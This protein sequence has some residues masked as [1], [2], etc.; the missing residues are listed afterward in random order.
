MQSLPAWHHRINMLIRLDIEIDQDR[1]LVRD[2]F[3]HRLLHIALVIAAAHPTDAIRLGELGEIGIFH[4][5][6][7]VAFVEQVLPLL[8]HA[9][10][11]VVEDG[12]FHRDVVLG[13]GRQL[14]AGHQ[15]L[16][17]PSM[18]I[19]SL[20]GLPSCAHRRRQ[21]IAHRAQ[22]AAGDH[23]PRIAPADELRRPH[24]ML[25]HARGEDRL[26]LGQ[27]R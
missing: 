8:D 14:V 5:R 27:R 23:L 9:L 10:E 22:A 4:D 13:D 15:E 3:L 12:D 21:A 24:L 7:A 1:P 17:S 19:T 16:A 11:I 26:A 18:S 25:A 2:H 6:L 20:P